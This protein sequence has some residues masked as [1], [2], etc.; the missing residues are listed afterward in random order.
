MFESLSSKLQNITSKMKGKARVT[1][2]D[3]KDMMREIRMALLEADVNYTVVKEF[4]AEMKE[5]CLNQS[6]QESFTPGQ[7]I[8]KIVHD[9]LVEL[10]GSGDERI[11]VSPQGFTV[12][13]LY[14]LQ[15][16]GKT[17]TAV[18]LAK[19]LKADGKKP[20]VASVDVHRPAAAKQLEV[21]AQANGIESY[22]EP[23]E[24]DAVKIADNAIARAKYMLCNFLIVDTAGRTVV[25]DELMGE[26]KAIDDHVNPTERI[27]VVDAMIGQEAVNVAQSFDTAI[28]MDGFIMTKLDGDARGGAALSIRK[29]TG[30]PIKYICVGEKIEAIE[31]FHPDRMAD[32]I[33]GMGDVVSLFEKAS[34]TIDQDAAMKTAERMMSNQFDLNDLLDQFIQIKKMGSMKDVLGMIPGVAGKVDESQIDDHIIDKNMAII[35]AMTKKER[36]CPQI[37]N[38]SRRKRI[39]AGSGTTVQDVNTLMKQYDQTSQMMKRFTKGGFK[40][41]KGLGAMGGFPGGKFPGMG[42]FPGGKKGWF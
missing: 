28:G 32:R 40:L 20:M 31:V 41:P 29:I 36:R 1:E 10:L 18:K 35:R 14:G 39:A 6:V 33:L 8:V 42:G 19:I 26:L 17:T 24:S 11:K 30:K 3:I 7:Q 27:L 5:K 2:Q 22:I 15:G 25:D 34:Q 38:A 4:C 21:L 37:L 16:A 13:M 23:E 12:I 9:S